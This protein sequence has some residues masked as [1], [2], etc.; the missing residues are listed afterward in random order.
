MSVWNLKKRK[1]GHFQRQKTITTIKILTTQRENSS[2]SRTAP[3]ESFTL[4]MCR[5][6]H[7]RRRTCQARLPKF[8]AAVP[9]FLGILESWRLSILGCYVGKMAEPNSDA[10]GAAAQ[11][12]GSRAFQA[13]RERLGS[14]AWHVR[15]RAW[16]P[17]HL[18][19]VKRST[20]AVRETLDFS[21]CVYTRVSV[22]RHLFSN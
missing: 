13:E 15:R 21:L 11:T 5:G 14:R 7:A 16:I 19:S 9:R 18:Q 1:K 22:S 2:V 3:A 12:F 8:W 17:R 10:R 6:I 4:R 20:G